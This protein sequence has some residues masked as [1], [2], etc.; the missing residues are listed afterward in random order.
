MPTGIARNSTA[1]V[2]SADARNNTITVQQDGGKAT[3]YDPKRL[4]GVNAYR[5]TQKE[6]A[7]GDRIQFTA[8]NRDLGVNNRDLGTITKLESGKG[9]CPDGRQKRTHQSSSTRSK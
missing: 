6:F 4:K 1:V 5:E 7:T 2:L 8:K 3:T 9:D